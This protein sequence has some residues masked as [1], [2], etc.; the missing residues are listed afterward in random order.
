LTV[1]LPTILISFGQGILLTTLPLF[2]SEFTDSYSLISFVVSAAALGTLLMDVP[3]GAILGRLGLRTTM[4]GGTLLVCLGTL[5]LAFVDDIRAAMVLRVLAGV[6]TAFW[7]LSRHA[8]IASATPVDQ[9]GRV[10]STFGGVNRMGV[11][12]GPAAGGFIASTA[13]LRPSFIVAGSMSLV[14]LFVAYK[15]V[16]E[17]EELGTGKPGRWSIVGRTMRTYWRD[18]SAAGVAQIFAQMVRTGRLLIIPLFAANELGLGA[19]QIGLI[20]SISSVIEVVMFFPAGV[21]MDR[22]GRKTASVPCFAIMAIGM[23]LIPL[24]SGF[25]GLLLVS[26]FI[27]VGNGLGSGSMMT[28][29]AD[30][31]PPEATGEFLGIWRLIGDS[32]G[33]LG[34]IVVGVVAGLLSLQGSAWALSVV[35]VLAALSLALL[36]RETRV[37]PVKVSQSGTSAGGV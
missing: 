3:A 26:C 24:T 4:L 13:G 14:A 7:G 15:Y 6:G 31:A 29:G 12:L 23:A 34:P 32:G 28:L 17:R 33:F 36:V 19:A 22:F 11:L 27:G 16:H 5:P 35:G 25:V 9:R 8:L 30:L 37:V 2:A 21:L 1:F 18:L 10:L 20:M